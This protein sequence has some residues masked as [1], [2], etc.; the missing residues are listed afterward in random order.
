MSL[1]YLK[2]YIE[3]CKNHNVKPN[4]LELYFKF[5]VDKELWNE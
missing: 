3:T 4:I 2:Q 5:I 1:K